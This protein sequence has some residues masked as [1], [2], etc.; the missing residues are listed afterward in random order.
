M[1][2]WRLVPVH[3][4]PLTGLSARLGKLIM[5]IRCSL[6]FSDDLQAASIQEGLV[7][8]QVGLPVGVATTQIRL[9]IGESTVVAGPN[10]VGKSAL[11]GEINRCIAGVH[12]VETFFGNRQIQFQSEE[13]DQVGNLK[14][15]QG[16][17]RDHV[18][19]F[20]HPWGEQHLKSVVRRI[21]T[22]QFQNTNDIVRSQDSGLAFAEAKAKHPEVLAR[23]NGVFEAARLP[24]RIVLR[25]GLL[26]AERDGSEYGIERMS[27][28][29]RAALLVV[30]AVLIQPANSF[31]IIDEPERHLNPGISGPLLSALHR[32]RADIGYVFS[33]HDLNMME[34]LRPDQ[35]IHVRDSK[36]VMQ[37]PEQRIYHASIIVEDGGLPED[38][39]YAILGG[40]RRLLLVEGTNASEDQ[41]LYTHL[42]TD[43]HVVARGGWETV[44][45][46]VRALRGNND[47]HWLA[48]AG[49][50]D[51][52]GR[53]ENERAAMASERVF[54][55]PVPTI[56][57][58]FLHRTALEQMA[59]AAH[60]LHGGLSGPERLAAMDAELPQLLLSC[61][62]EIIA[63][64][65]VWESSRELSARKPSVRSVRDGQATIP[66]I[67]LA[68]IRMRLESE[69]DAALESDDP[70]RM[71]SSIP[72]KSTA[73]PARVANT[74][75]FAS[76]NDY[77]RAVLQQIEF[78]SEAGIAISGA[79]RG[80]MP[81]LN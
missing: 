67:D 77:K 75:G 69:F 20:R 30:G 11:L 46:G 26:K 19:R 43:W 70:S 14:V 31:I 25:D 36:I 7:P 1:V 29:E 62:E 74:I 34:W 58:L 5:E 52:D 40:R 21:T 23:L 49:L 42:Y 12:G 44:T 28:G 8:G 13:I 10:G 47:Y 71:L 81:S 4:G 76:F 9:A 73:I 6:Y 63:R 66:A 72:L 45:T 15:L 68:P 38:L 17:V 79:L 50:I 51:A 24:V 35:I 54:T 80:I 65:V 60:S 16:Q 2:P 57:N 78:K 53:D 64:R 59:E 37:D 56:E 33:T 41:S 48:A 61:K 22:L 39:R 27:D 18:T 3:P 32:T 55:L